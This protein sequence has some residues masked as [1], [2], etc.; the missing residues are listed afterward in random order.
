MA[1]FLLRV[2]NPDQYFFY[3]KNEDKHFEKGWYH[4][5]ETYAPVGPFDTIQ[6]A[7]EG[8]VLYCKGLDEQSK[9]G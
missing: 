2:E 9:Q 3:I 1:K 6:D 5:D 8:F 4:A 7:Y